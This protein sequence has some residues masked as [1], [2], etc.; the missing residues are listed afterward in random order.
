MIVAALVLNYNDASQTLDCLSDLAEL[1]SNLRLY[2]VDNGSTDGSASKLRQSAIPDETIVLEDNFGFAKGMNKG[3][4]A[5]LTKEAD[6][7]WI[8]NNDIKIPTEF[9]LDELITIVSE[10]DV[11]A[12]SPLIRHPDGE[13]WFSQ[14]EL[15]M[16]KINARNLTHSITGIVETD[17][18]PLA[19]ALV[20]ASLLR[21]VPIPEGYFMYWEDVEWAVRA[22]E[23]GYRLVTTADV[24][25]IHD[26]GSSSNQA[27]KSYYTARNRW[28]FARRFS[29]RVGSWRTP[30]LWL[31]FQL[32]LGRVLD[33]D[34]KAI[35][36]LW[37]GA[38]D[39]ALGKTGK[40]S[41]P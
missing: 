4:D 20:D 10:D 25:V 34:V 30:Y 3:I 35:T 16:E 28:L 11:G 12:V 8:L 5:A 31:L 29:Q 6:Y 23:A 18:M 24:N 36:A 40:G 7:I 27:L 22:R 33:R 15:D 26:A 21:D 37:K 9:S 13:I 2:A 1:S 41:Y 32:T 38:V 19:A 17:H 14:S 39:G